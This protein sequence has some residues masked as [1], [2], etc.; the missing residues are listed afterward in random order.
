M[1]TASKEIRLIAPRWFAIASLSL[2]ALFLLPNLHASTLTYES[3]SE[4]AQAHLTLLR[5]G[6]AIVLMDDASGRTVASAP[7]AATTGVVVRG[8]SGAH[9]DTLTVDLSAGLRLPGGIDYDGGAGGWD[10][11][12]L[13]GDGGEAQRVRQLSSSAGIIDAGGVT[14]RYDNLEPLTDIAVATNYLFTATS[15]GEEI[16]VVD[17]PVVSGTQTTEINSGASG[18][19][20]LTDIANKQNVTINTGGGTDIV[21]VNNP[22]P[23]AGMATL[24]VNGDTAAE[25]FNVTPSATI[26]YTVNGGAPL[27][28]GTGDILVV[29]LGGTTGQALSVASDANGLQGAFTFSNRQSVTFTQIET[30]NPTDLVI[31]KIGPDT[32][33]AGADVGYTITIQNLGANDAA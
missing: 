27:P 9:N 12:V 30:I 29:E 7:A 20:E 32:I 13:R 3:H 17:G 28:P 5:L 25:R 1:T 16:N 26:P 18:T 4:A 33:N 8:A 10:T 21:T 14:I 19:F 11:L 23:G 24:T 22:N 6:S 2:S 15:G 31:S